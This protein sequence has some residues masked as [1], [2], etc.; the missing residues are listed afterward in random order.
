MGIVN[1]GI[2]RIHFDVPREV[3]AFSPRDG[4][5]ELDI[6]VKHKA[7]VNILSDGDNHRGLVSL[8]P[9]ALFSFYKLTNNKRKEQ[10][11]IE[12]VQI[13]YLIQEFKRKAKPVMIF[14]LILI[15]ILKHANE[16]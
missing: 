15:E 13:K 6:D 10:E 9:I 3:R 1:G 7:A 2:K 11:N 5:I 12:N 8:R 14:Q 16:R 4:C